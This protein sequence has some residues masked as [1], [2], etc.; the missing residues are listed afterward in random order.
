VGR[1]RI[2]VADVGAHDN[3]VELR[4]YA[5]E[6]RIHEALAAPL[7]L[8]TGQ[9]DV[10]LS[11]ADLDRHGTSRM[12][13]VDLRMHESANWALRIAFTPTIPIRQSVHS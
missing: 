9:L 5:R 7:E 1:R 10:T 8:I 2:G 13:L 11:F 12:R 6:R 4:R 3:A